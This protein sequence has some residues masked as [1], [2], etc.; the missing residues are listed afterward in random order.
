MERITK[1]F[2]GV[3]A[4]DAVDLTLKEGEI[5][6]VIGE[7]G[8]GKSTL[9]RVL[10]GLYPPDDGRIRVRGKEVKIGSPRDALG[11]GIGMVHQH[12]ML[13]DR[14][15]VT[16]NIMLGAEGGLVLEQ[17]RAAQRVSELARTYGL[18]VNPKTRVEDLSV[19]QQQRV[20]ILK[21]L[22]RG[23][24][25]LI[26]DEPTAVL[27]PT[28][29]QELFANLRRLRD[30]GKTVVFI[31]HKLDEVLEIADRIT[32]LRRGRVV[33]E[34]APAETSK[35]E[36]AEMMV[37][38][39]V[40]FR[41][42]RPRVSPGPPVLRLSGVRLG[43]ELHGIDLEVRAG[44]IVGVAGV[45]GNGQLALA[46][47]V[48]GLRHPHGGRIE[49][50]G[51]DV[52]TRP[53]A[54]IREMGVAYV[55]EDR[56]GRGLVLDMTVWENT[57]LGRQCRPEF[58]RRLG[59]L[60]IHAIKAMA[61]RLVDRFDVRTRGIGVA[62]ATL[63]GGNQQKLILARELDTGPMLLVA[64]Q[65]TRGLDVGAIEFVWRHLLDEKAAGKAVLLISAEL[66]EIYALADRIVTIY[67]GRLTGEYAPD[68]PAEDVGVGMCG[69]VEAGAA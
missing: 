25:L 42:E 45:E 53:V 67:E 50:D 1:R 38:R 64:H 41:L 48:V 56:H 57:L 68:A 47:S 66:D 60:A 39:P 5:H 46:E 10:Y 13:V 9:M 34:T 62:A 32:V 24:D 44:E 35:D 61:A 4:N 19:G 43:E 8:A 59:L 58:L 21:A 12:F 3:V 2:P 54:E 22:Y 29:D 6:A 55:P 49:I 7:N 27:A 16:E 30:D 23:V 36:L 51:K 18:G 63:S 11:L 14:F 33:G 31:S 65:P 20:E 37:G 52:T 69:G 28:E 17:D 26:L 15:T 40:L